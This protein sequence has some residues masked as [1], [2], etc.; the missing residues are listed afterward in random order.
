MHKNVMQQLFTTEDTEST[1]KCQS[2]S[3]VCGRFG[4]TP[5]QRCTFEEFALHGLNH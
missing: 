2:V 3:C 5:L 1:E 4:E